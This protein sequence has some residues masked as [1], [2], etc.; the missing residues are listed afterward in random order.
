MP[1]KNVVSQGVAPLSG[2]AQLEKIF[3][4]TAIISVKYDSNMSNKTI[5]DTESKNQVG[6]W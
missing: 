6:T 1:K 2:Q 5:Y 4:M 3:H